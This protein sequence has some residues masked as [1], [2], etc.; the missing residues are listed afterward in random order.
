MME[1]AVFGNGLTVCQ[2]DRHWDGHS[3]HADSNSIAQTM[4]RKRRRRVGGEG[5]EEKEGKP[6][7]DRGSLPMAMNQRDEKKERI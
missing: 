7:R 2:D 5:D 6:H 1:M 3:E 4:S